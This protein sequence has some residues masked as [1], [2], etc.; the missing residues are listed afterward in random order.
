MNQRRRQVALVAYRALSD[1]AGKGAFFLVTLV[2]AR[3]LSQDAFGLFSLGTTVGWT[4]VG[5]HG[6]SNFALTPVAVPGGFEIA[7]VRRPS[8]QAG[9]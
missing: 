9:E 1:V 4:V 7:F 5:R 6:R 2:A 3:R 8:R